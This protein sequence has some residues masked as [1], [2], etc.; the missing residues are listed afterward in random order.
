[1]WLLM[2]LGLACTANKYTPPDTGEDTAAR[3]AQGD[4]GAGGEGSGGD[5]SGDD[6]SGGDGSGDDG[7]GDDGSGGDGSGG[8]E[9][10]IPALGDPVDAPLA[11]TTWRAPFGSMQISDPPE[12]GTLLDL[13]LDEDA[14]LFN[15]DWASA[16]SFG[17]VVALGVDGG[18]DPCESV[19]ALPAA[20][21][22]ENPLFRIDETE[23]VISSG[24]TPV[25][26]L[27]AEMLGVLSGDGGAWTWGALRATI[28]TRDFQVQ[29]DESGLD[30]CELLEGFGTSCVACEDG[31]ELCMRLVVDELVAEPF[32]GDFDPNAGEGC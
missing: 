25:T 24:E 4:D 7:S 22:S 23:I 28:D 17:M 12:G 29:L 16:T 27:D 21:F 19:Q 18:Q 2:I 20:D 13:L 8:E 14:L 10:E 5:G 6:G 26:M 11:G 9:F 32:S 15:V 1:M 30:A 31:E 3:G